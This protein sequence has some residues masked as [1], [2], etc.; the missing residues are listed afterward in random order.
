MTDNAFAYTRSRLF[1][2]ALADIG[3]RHLT[4]RPYTPRTNGKA[5]RF[6]QTCLREWLYAR[7]YT[8]SSHR[9]ADMPT[10]LHHYNHHR[11][12]AGILAATPAA[13]LNNLLGND[14]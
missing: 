13:R 1:N 9:S 3:A 11:P 5:E 2:A 10:W 7:T 4:T 6:I 8:S 14:T 12:H